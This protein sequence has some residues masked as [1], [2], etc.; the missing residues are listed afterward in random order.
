[1]RVEEKK[2]RRGK[3]G[4]LSYIRMSERGRDG[5]REITCLKTKNRL[6]TDFSRFLATNWFCDVTIA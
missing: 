2:Q 5:N 1:M 6:S 3:R 4:K